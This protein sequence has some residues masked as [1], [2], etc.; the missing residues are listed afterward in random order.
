MHLPIMRCVLRLLLGGLLV[1]GVFQSAWAGEYQKTDGTIIRGEVSSC[2]EFG[3]IVRL[4]VGGFSERVPW[5]RFTEET[6]RVLVQDPRAKEFVEPFIEPEPSE[7]PKPADKKITIKPVPRVELP[8]GRPSLLSAFTLPGGFLMLAAFYLANLFAAYAVAVFRNRPVALV[9]I[10]SAVLPWVGPVLFLA[11][12]SA[13]VAPGSEPAGAEVPTGA[14]EG[15]NPLAHPG[16][17]APAGLSLAAASDKGGPSYIQPATYTRGD[18][19]FNRRFFETKFPG[20]FRVVPN[21]AE[22]DLVI[23]IR[24]GRTEYIGRRISRISS[25]DLHIQPLKSGAQEISITFA[26]VTQVQ[27]RH[28]DAAS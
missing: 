16:M 5:G 23:V 2:N 21:E 19:T 10:V 7:R 18:T 25:T 24:A 26:E 12:P 3:L 6:L 20:L 14:T 9:A 1:L 8:E 4:A 28:K 22:K 11:M 13:D 17:A 27:I 15:V